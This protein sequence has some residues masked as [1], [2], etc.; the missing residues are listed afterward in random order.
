MNE[1]FELELWRIIGQGNDESGGGYPSGGRGSL[2]HKSCAVGVFSS[3][4]MMSFGALYDCDKI[5]N[6][7]ENIMK[8]INWGTRSW[9]TPVCLRF[10]SYVSWFSKLGA[11]VYMAML[12][13]R[14]NLRLLL[15]HPCMQAHTR[16]IMAVS[17][18]GLATGMSNARAKLT[19][20]TT[21]Y[22]KRNFFIRF[23]SGNGG[24]AASS[25]TLSPTLS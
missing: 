12:H 4:L 20:E 17:T 15:P 2:V 14:V 10:S 8:H 18:M 25:S 22:R 9:G 5:R 11:L 3:C 24:S 7:L 19:G 6:S 1:L 21:E 13:G 16:V 23:R